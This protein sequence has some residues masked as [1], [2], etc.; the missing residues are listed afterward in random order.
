MRSQSVE[1]F[2]QLWPSVHLSLIGIFV[3]LLLGVKTWYSVGR[4]IEMS[5]QEHA[6]DVRLTRRQKEE[7]WISV[8]VIAVTIFQTLYEES[9]FMNWLV[10]SVVLLCAISWPAAFFLGIRNSKKKPE[11]SK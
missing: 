2:I 7:C 11:K 9:V 6:R 3:A 5:R 4:H 10:W 8:F 1:E